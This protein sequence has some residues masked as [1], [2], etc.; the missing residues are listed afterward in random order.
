M[1]L[2]IERKF[3]VDL[4][5][6]D[7]ESY[8]GNSIKQGYIAQTVENTV[9]RV[10]VSNVAYLTIKGANNGM[11]R[12]EFE[13]QIPLKD[14]YEMIE[15]FCEEKI[16]KDRYLIEYKGK[17]WELDVFKGDNEGLVIAEIELESEDEFFNIPHWVGEE[18]T[19]DK[20][21]YNNKLLEKP[22]KT[23]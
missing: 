23:W 13:Y 9:V 15:D 20:R 1:G 4:K 3:L 11:T 7:L 6:F 17:T 16:E 2:E 8:E 21:Y 19:D 14:A 12:K 5:K 10:R 18:V 22:F